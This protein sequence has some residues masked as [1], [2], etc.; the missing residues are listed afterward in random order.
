MTK[1]KTDL[2]QGLAAIRRTES[3]NFDVIKNIKKNRI[4]TL[5]FV[6]YGC[7]TLTQRHNRVGRK[8]F[9]PKRDAVQATAGDDVTRFKI[10]APY[11]IFCA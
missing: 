8:I 7:E 11:H 3:L 5:L 1:L 9:G 10:S 4:I 2:K 6:L